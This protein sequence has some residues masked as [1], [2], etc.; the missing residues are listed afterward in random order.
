MLSGRGEA[1]NITFRI[2]SYPGIPENPEIYLAGSFNNWNPG[3]EDYKLHKTAAGYEISLELTSKSSIEYKFTLGSWDTVEKG[4]EFREIA[5]RTIIIPDSTITID[6]QVLN[7]RNIEMEQDQRL[8]T[9][10]GDVQYIQ[11][12]Y[13]PQLDRYRTIRVYLPPDYNI[14][15]NR[16]PVIYMHD[17]QN[18]FDNATSFAGEWQIDE[19]LERL[20]RE[21]RFQ[22]TIVV[23]ID[24][25][26]QKRFDEYCPWKN[27]QY[28][29]GEGDRYVKFLATTLKP[30]IDEH[31]RTL[32]SGNDTAIAGSSLGGLIALYA[33]CKHPDVFGKAGVFSP[34]FWVAKKDIVKYVKKH[35]LSS[36]SRVYVDVGT[37]EGN[38]SEQ[39]KA[40]LQDAEEISK[41]L[42]KNGLP[43]SNLRLFIDKGALHNE[44][45]WAK[46][47]PDALLWLF[48]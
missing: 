4:V 28:G 8:S 41:L 6:H 30:W 31:Y 33:A 27:P 40:Y 29:G 23:G 35:H 26:H 2:S 45:H 9:K 42:R 11:D 13:M 39:N 14:T 44:R 15:D 22:G 17:G 32:S 36:S 46:R 48:K 7:W 21:N 38:N 5:N 43:E 34:A 20:F 37:E 1:V 47:F 10:T 25:H 12:F 18:L 24:N 19:T 16:Y 3:A